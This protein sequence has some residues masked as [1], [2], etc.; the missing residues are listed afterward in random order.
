MS[1][2][3]V[4]LCACVCM[5]AD[6]RALQACSVCQQHT[7]TPAVQAS[8]VTAQSLLTWCDSKQLAAVSG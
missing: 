6:T 1:V 7:C 2:T 8:T 3:Q 4:S 5:C